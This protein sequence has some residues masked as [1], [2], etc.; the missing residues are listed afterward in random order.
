MNTQ[1]QAFVRI[2]PAA[3]QTRATIMV[4]AMNRGP[5]GLTADEVSETWHCPHNH[6]SP[7]I[8]E[9]VRTGELVPAGRRR[10]TR[11]G[12]LAEVYVAAKFASSAADRPVRIPQSL[13]PGLEGV[14]RDDG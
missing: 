13:F 3:E 7:R 9:L 5:Y 12:R 4:F 10:P 8:V 14:H 6:T 11:A 2:Q 1:T